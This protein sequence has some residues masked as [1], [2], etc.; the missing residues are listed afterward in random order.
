MKYTILG[1]QQQKLLDNNL[2]VMDALILSAIKD[3]YSSN[4]MEYE[5]I[6]NNRYMWVNF[7]YFLNEVPLIGSRSN[8]LRRIKKYSESGFLL[9]QIKHIKDNKKGTYAYIYPTKELFS[10]SDYD[11]YVKMTQ[12]VCQNDIGGMSKRHNKDTS[13][14][15]TSIKD[16]YIQDIKEIRSNYKGTK[17]KAVA[18]KKLPKLIKEYGKE[19]LIRTV[20]RYNK[21]VLLQRATGFNLHYKNE[22][23]FWNGG[24]MDYLDL[25]YSN[26]ETIQPTN[27]T[28]YKFDENPY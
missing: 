20:E 1:F 3:M 15:D 26:Q 23:T 17:T 24:F 2:D 12:G 18:D 10:L 14:I 22:S 5:I 4:S 25:N 19:Q 13:I 16:I 7:N 6:D 27:N 21:F 8:L 11:G 9:K 28:K